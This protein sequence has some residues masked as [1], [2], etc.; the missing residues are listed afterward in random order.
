MFKFMQCWFPFRHCWHYGGVAK[1]R[2]ESGCANG[3]QE[4][5]YTKVCCKCGREK[6]TEW[7]K[8]T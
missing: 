5:R 1:T 2:A 8:S 7:L 4:V 3:K 6:L